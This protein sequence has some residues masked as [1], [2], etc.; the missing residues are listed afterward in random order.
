MGGILLLMTKQP[1]AIVNRLK[2][3]EGQSA[4]LR[5]ALELGQSCEKVIPQFLAVKGALDAS[6][7]EYLRVSLEECKGKKSVEE[8][9]QILNL[10]LKKIK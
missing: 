8:M 1:K 5:E 6:L 9:G 4:S 2:R 10:V 3:V 7:Q